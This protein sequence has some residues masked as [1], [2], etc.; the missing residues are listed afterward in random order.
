MVVKNVKK[1]WNS[2]SNLLINEGK[3]KNQIIL[4]KTKP[5]KTTTKLVIKNLIK[6]LQQHRRMFLSV[7]FLLGTTEDKIRKIHNL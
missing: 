7:L 6:H 2:N 4:K 3:E 1:K 5:Y